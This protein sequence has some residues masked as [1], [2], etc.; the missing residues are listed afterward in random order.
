MLDKTNKTEIKEDLTELGQELVVDEA[1]GKTRE[2]VDERDMSGEK[3]I[4]ISATGSRKKRY[5]ARNMGQAQKKTG[6]S[7]G[8]RKRSAIKTL[9]SKKKKF[10]KAISTKSAKKIKR[11]KKKRKAMGIAS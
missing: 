10:G 2:M 8:Q 7:A 11:A 9:K 4:R 3:K 1:V 6:R 5:V